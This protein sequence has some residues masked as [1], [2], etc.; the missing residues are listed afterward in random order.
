M[1][2]GGPPIAARD[3][4]PDSSNDDGDDDQGVK[5]DEHDERENLWEGRSER[6]RGCRY[7]QDFNRAEKDGDEE[8]ED[9]DDDDDYEDVS[10]NE[11]VDSDS[12]SD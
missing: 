9:D 1:L 11:D 10:Y 8:E 12:D 4:E 6:A 2:T 5:E 3:A 7:A